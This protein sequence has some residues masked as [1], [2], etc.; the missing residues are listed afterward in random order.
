MPGQ[1]AG[2][3]KCKILASQPQNSCQLRA[4]LG[5]ACGFL[6]LEPS[7]TMFHLHSCKTKG[8]SSGFLSCKSG[9]SMRIVIA[10]S[11][12]PF[13]KF[14]GFDWKIPNLQAKPPMSGHHSHP[15]PTGLVVGEL[16]TSVIMEG[17]SV[18]ARVK[19]HFDTAMQQRHLQRKPSCL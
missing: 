9:F 7:F 3:G 1:G 8:A 17:V 15:K 6:L 13:F 10:S 2:L 4:S 16:V 14:H 12:G 5:T 11:W 19:K 18:L